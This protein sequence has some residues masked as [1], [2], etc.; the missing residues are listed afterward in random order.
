MGA[1]TAK[2]PKRPAARVTKT[3][4]AGVK[5]GAKAKPAGQAAEAIAAALS[6]AAEPIG[7]AA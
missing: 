5:L 6:T 7:G 3:T 1:K 4:L 2:P